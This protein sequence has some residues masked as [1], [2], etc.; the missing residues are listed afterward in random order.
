MVILTAGDRQV[1]LSFRNFA[2]AL[3][4]HRNIARVKSGWHLSGSS[5]NA[6]TKRRFFQAQRCLRRTATRLL[7]MLVFPRDMWGNFSLVK[8]SWRA[9]KLSKRASRASAT[10][11]E[12]D[13]IQQSM[14]IKQLSASLFRFPTTSPDS[15][16]EKLPKHRIFS[17]SIF[18]KKAVS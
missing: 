1:Y 18:S 6:H 3:A 5:N 7:P 4:L 14:R 12:I 10:C 15:G 2:A 13:G 16:G 9:G 8:A 11:S 17:I